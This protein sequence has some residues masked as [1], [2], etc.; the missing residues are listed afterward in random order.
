MHLDGPHAEKIA[1]I[2][3]NSSM[4]QDGPLAEMFI[5]TRMHLL[6]GHLAEKIDIMMIPACTWM[7][8]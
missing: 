5:S 6:D 4:H 7:A 1:D 8:P 3:I 2:I